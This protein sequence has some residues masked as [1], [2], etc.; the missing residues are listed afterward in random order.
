MDQH[1]LRTRNAFREI[2]ENRDL[3][4]TQS[5]LFARR[6]GPRE[7]RIRAIYGRSHQLAIQL[8][9]LV[10]AIVEYNDF[11]GTNEREIQRVKE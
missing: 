3:H 9:K 1:A 7:M 6:L 10:V 2:R 5:A 8:F 11:S 4:I